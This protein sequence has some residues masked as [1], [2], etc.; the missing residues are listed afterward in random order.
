MVELVIRHAVKHGP[1]VFVDSTIQINQNCDAKIGS[2]EYWWRSRGIYG[3]CSLDQRAF[4]TESPIPW[5][6]GFGDLCTIPRVEGLE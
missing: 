6:H 2:S 3:I 1:V 4:S 5:H